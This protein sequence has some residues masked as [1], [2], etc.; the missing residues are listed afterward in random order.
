MPAPGLAEERADALAEPAEAVHADAV[1]HL[2]GIHARVSQRRDRDLVSARVKRGGKRLRHALL[3][4]DD[5]RVELGEHQ[6]P[7]GAVLRTRR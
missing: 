5:R 4:A 7:H 6:H 3:A 2:I 1:A